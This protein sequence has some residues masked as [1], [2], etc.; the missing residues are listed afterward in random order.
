M[1]LYY[2]L[3]SVV[4]LHF[5]RFTIVT[6]VIEDKVTLARG[7]KF[8]RHMAVTLAYER[9]DASLHYHGVRGK[10]EYIHQELY[11][12]LHEAYEEVKM[13]EAVVMSGVRMN[14]I[15]MLLASVRLLIAWKHHDRMKEVCEVSDLCR[16]AV[17]DLFPNFGEH[18][19]VAL[20]DI[21]YIDEG[22]Q[23]TESEWDQ[24]VDFPT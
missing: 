8:V 6:M 16:K 17:M 18:T 7:L 4:L 20:M 11:R 10:D 9:N 22:S 23:E 12:L 5:G 13:W 21:L 19:T 2:L 1:L 3:Y 14:H 15:G 24:E